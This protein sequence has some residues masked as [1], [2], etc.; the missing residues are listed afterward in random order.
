MTVAHTGHV[1]KEGLPDD[2]FHMQQLALA[3]IGNEIPSP[4]AIQAAYSHASSAEHP[5][6]NALNT[7]AIGRSILLK[8]HGRMEVSNQM[9][10]SKNLIKLLGLKVVGPDFSV[11]DMISFFK[12]F[13]GLPED[14]IPVFISSCGLELQRAN[15]ALSGKVL[16]PLAQGLK[17]IQ[18]DSDVLLKWG[19]EPFVEFNQKWNPLADIAKSIVS[20]GVGFKKVLGGTAAQLQWFE[21]VPICITLFSEIPSGI[22]KLGGVTEPPLDDCVVFMKMI[23][24]CGDAD[25]VEAMMEALDK[26]P[27]KLAIPDIALKLFKLPM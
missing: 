22:I 9:E 6:L 14:G 13:D 7:F 4:Y 10:K 20:N 1:E 19:T 11:D 16:T 3:A 15:V 17:C 8:A 5:L 23:V 26:E 2:L 12:L 25:N 24:K 21:V 18:D 27:I